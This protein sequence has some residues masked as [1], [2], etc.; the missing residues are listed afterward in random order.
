[1]GEACS[2]DGRDEICKQNFGRETN[3]WNYTTTSKYVLMALCSV[4]KGQGLHL[5]YTL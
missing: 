1:M 3:A 5:T 2:T 4:K